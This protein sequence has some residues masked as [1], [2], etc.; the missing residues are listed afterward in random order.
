MLQTHS[1]YRH[2]IKLNFT[3]EVALKQIFHKDEVT[4]ESSD[5]MTEVPHYDQML[6]SI[7]FLE[8]SN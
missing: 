6:D 7:V 5:I 3:L 8:N 4:G 2:Y 1:T